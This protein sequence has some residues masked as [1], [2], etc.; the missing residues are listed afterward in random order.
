[1]RSIVVVLFLSLGALLTLSANATVWVNRTVFDTDEFVATV[2]EVLDDETVQQDIATRLSASLVTQGD[3]EA[4]IEE[5]LPEGLKFLAPVLTVTAQDLIERTVLRV[6]ESDQIADVVDAALR[7]VHRQVLF[8]IEGE[9]TIVFEDNKVIL[10]L[11]PVLLSVAE[12]LG[13][14]D[15]NG[16]LAGIDIPEDAG[17]I[18]LVDDAPKASAIQDLLA[19]HEQITWAVVAA[20]LAC[21]A[22]AV[23]FAR[24]KRAA[25][26]NVGVIVVLVGLLA[27]IL[28]LPI[29]PIVAGFAQ[30]E[31]SA[32][33]VFDALVDRYRTQSFW[34]V[35]LGVLIVIGTTLAGHSGFARAIRL[36]V[37][38]PG[39]E[40]LPD[41]AAEAAASST[42]LRVIGL[43]V[44]A[45][46]LVVWP[47]PTSR[48][49]ITVFSL[50]A[51]YFALLW[52]LTSE[53]QWAQKARGQFNAWARPQ[54]QGSESPSW[55][56]RNLLWLRVAGVLL[57]VAA[58]VFIPGLDIGAIV[59]VIAAVLIY[60][61]AIDWLGSKKTQ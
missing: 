34:L 43:V 26:R 28:L 54:A 30:E 19:I 4:R 36:R 32:R 18:V 2:R 50:M 51:A 56:A 27:V 60:L 44:A 53:A 46:L 47:E 45:L 41:L 33:I 14:D 10:D 24:D 20:A 37:R 22:V 40:P 11:R 42:A 58:L 29:R 13:V 23:V 25:V 16:F 12:Q 6:L 48:V 8:I 59:G 17:R 31:D 21:F 9:G 1:M 15:P 3:V 52:L 35:I 38:N 39:N 5:S 7:Q 55:I 57:G 49:Y 61:A